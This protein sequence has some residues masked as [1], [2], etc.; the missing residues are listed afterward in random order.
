MTSDHIFSP[1]YTDMYQ[2]TMGQ[3]YFMNGRHEQ[4]ACFDYFFRKLPFKGGYVVFAGLGEFLKA[5]TEL[6]FTED[7]LD[8]LHAKGLHTDY[9]E[10]LKSYRFKG[11]IQGVREGELVFPSEPILRVEGGL[12]ETQLIET[13]LLNFLNFQSLIATKANR[14]RHSAGKRLLSDF[15]LR[16][17]QGTGGLQASRAAVIGGFD[18][19]SNVLAAKIYGSEPSGTMAHSFI[20]SCDSELEAFEEYAR[21]FPDNCVLLV[22]TYNTLKSGVPNAIKVARLLEKEGKKLKGIRLDSGDLAYL[23][24]KSREMLDRENLNYVKIVASNQLDEHVIKSLLDQE[25]P[26]DLFGVGTSMI[27][28][29]PDGAIDG[30]YKIAWSEGEGRLKISENVQKTTLPGKKRVLRYKDDEG[31]FY[32]DCIA[33]EGEEPD[34]MVHPVHKEKSLDLSGLSYEEIFVSHI[35]DGEI[36]G[37]LPSLSEIRGRVESRLKLLPEEHKRFDFPHIY[38]VG[39]SEQLQQLRDEIVKNYQKHL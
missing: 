29:K 28:G 10:Y 24:K 39:I 35:I 15:G 22:D 25:A 21:A 4:P 27:I 6:R 37:S 19:T 18:N 14:I 11:H 1:L 8:Y 20:E 38:K 36:N 34:K 16:R 33:L 3:A 9:I 26:I 2:L 7:E 13:L 5:L 30:V 31:C 23:S 32:A 12:L 17:A